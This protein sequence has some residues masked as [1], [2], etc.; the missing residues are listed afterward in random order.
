MSD[1]PSPL[2]WEEARDENAREDVYR[3]RYE[4]Y[5]SQKEYLPGTEHD[6]RRVWLPHDE[7]S[8]HFL[9]R[10]GDGRLAAVGTATPADEPSL[11]DEWR[12]IFELDR[13]KELLPQTV[14][15]SRVIVAREAR[16]TSL[17]GQMC[18]RL[19]VLLLEEGYR[20]AVHYCAPAMTPMYERLG[21]RLYG[22]GKTMRSGAFRLP[23]IL[24]PD[25]EAY[26]K[27]VRSPF[28]RIERPDEEKRRGAER[29]LRVCPELATLPLCAMTAPSRERRLVEL[30]PPLRLAAPGLRRAALR[31]SIFPM[32]AG[33]SLAAQG[34][35]EGSF[36]VLSGLMSAGSRLCGPGDAIHS[37]NEAVRAERDSL[38]LSAPLDPGD[39]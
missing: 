37:G 7:A 9:V 15:V 21:Y 28:R 34:V 23:M 3:F 31:G 32:R 27:R 36:L 25:D 24:V 20:Y 30:C 10:A 22:R 17:F 5:F 18:L 14:I 16:H 13:L 35:D 8:R 2:L 12:D 6:A 38:L 19:A 33:D 39:R 1:T 26:L 11:L 4:Q 29:A